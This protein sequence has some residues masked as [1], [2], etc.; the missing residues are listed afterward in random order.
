MRFLPEA[1]ASLA[2]QTT[3]LTWIVCYDGEAVP[4]ELKAAADTLRGLVPH[5]RVVASGRS[6]G[7]AMA[8]TTALAAVD[9]RW[10]AVLDADDV[11]LPGGLDVLVRA[12]HRSEVSWSAGKGVDIVGPKHVRYPDYLQPGRQRPGTVYDAYQANGFLPFPAAAVVWDTELVTSLGGW[13]ALPA[14]EDTNLLL[15]GTESR[16]GHYHGG[17][18]VYGYRK[19]AGQT[20]AASEYRRTVLPSDILHERRVSA[21]RTRIPGSRDTSVSSGRALRGPVHAAA[22]RH[23]AVEVVTRTGRPEGP[24]VMTEPSARPAAENSHPESAPGPGPVPTPGPGSIPVAQSPILCNEPGSFAWNVFHDRHPELLG[25]L[26]EDLP[27]PPQRWEALEALI[28]ETL[29]GTIEPPRPGAHDATV[30]ARWSEGYVGRPWADAPFLWAESYFYRRLLD[31]TGYFEAGPWH[32]LDPFGPAK[33]TELHD[34]TVDSELAGLDALFELTSAKRREAMVTA[35][36]WGN[37]ADLGFRITAGQALVLDADSLVVAD[38]RAAL[39]THLDEQTLDRVCLV[40]DNAGREL[41]ADLVLLDYL[42]HE[43]HATEAVLHVKPQPYY[44][45]DATTSDVP[46]C[47]RRLRR[48][49]GQAARVGDRLWHAIE[50]GRLEIRAHPFSCAPLSYRHMPDDLRRDFASST[51]TILKG[52]LNYRRLVGDVHRPATTPFAETVEYFP[53]SVATLRTLESEAVVG[54]HERTLASLNASGEDWRT[55]GTHALI[56]FRQ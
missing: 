39:W 40:A 16:P 26:R 32:A 14:G 41:L 22:A 36:L 6:G 42:L 38:D 31:A 18:A 10:L 25:Q 37:R 45:S 55:S 13:A 53:S 44:V 1:G 20:T 19:W 30:W 52:D 51:L 17:T 49:P 43:A 27:L 9:T 35:S 34:P 47:L 15:A 3:S 54:I 2:A 21:L 5:V 48:A 46:A 4:S 50:S 8:R 24:R 33:T 7:A 29:T 28:E 12:A 11:W 23:E 56:Q